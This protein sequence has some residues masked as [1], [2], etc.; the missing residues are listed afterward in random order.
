MMPSEQQALD[1]FDYFFTNIHPYCPV[2]NKSYFYQQWHT[3]RESISPLML[4]A[5]FAC[6]SLMLEEPGQGNKWLALASSRTPSSSFYLEI[7]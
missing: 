7:C 5:I 2:I 4:E 1:Y 6:A 3:A